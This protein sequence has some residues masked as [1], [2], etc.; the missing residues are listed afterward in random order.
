MSLP[1][2]TN[3]AYVRGF[4][5]PL[6]CYLLRRTILTPIDNRADDEHDAS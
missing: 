2:M 3:A 6:A 1:G 5:C 4:R